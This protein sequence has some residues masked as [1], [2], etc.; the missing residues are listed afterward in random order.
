MRLR[1]VGSVFWVIGLILLVLA[2]L[3]HFDVISQLAEPA[4][5]LAVAGL[6]VTLFAPLLSRR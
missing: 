3:G 6:V 5:W 1:S 4:F 2:L